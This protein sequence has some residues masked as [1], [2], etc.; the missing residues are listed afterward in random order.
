VPGGKKK[1]FLLWLTIGLP[2]LL[3]ILMTAVVAVVTILWRLEKATATGTP[4]PAATAESEGPRSLPFAPSGLPAHPSSRD[5]SPLLF[6]SFDGGMNDA[7]G[8]SPIL[9]QGVMYVPGVVGQAAYV[10]RGARIRFPA[11][12]HLDADEGTFEVWVRP[13]WNGG[14]GAHRNLLSCGTAGGI[15]FQKDSIDNLRVIFNR[16]AAEEG[17]YTNVADWRASQWHH[18]AY[19]WSN[20]G[21]QLQLFVDGLLRA[22]API[23]ARLP[24]LVA[25]EIDI[26]SDN[27]TAW[28][29]GALDELRIW[30]VVRSGS[31][32][33][34]S[35][36]APRG[37]Q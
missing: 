5:L 18:V 15:V 23:R 4:A 24:P 3:V 37:G 33:A 30:S 9:A 16:Y 31:Q 20:S 28:I 22:Q 35:A 1:R 29:E 32:I 26:G 19:T 2:L 17:V 25:Q 21:G 10:G 12:D 8:A 6:L 7:G 34:E 14:D 36:A 13:S 27:G 11:V